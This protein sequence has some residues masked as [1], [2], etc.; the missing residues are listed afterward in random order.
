[1]CVVDM[2]SPC[3]RM[4]YWPLKAIDFKSPSGHSPFRALCLTGDS[5]N[6]RKTCAVRILLRFG[7]RLVVGDDPPNGHFQPIVQHGD[8]LAYSGFIGLSKYSNKTPR[9][10][11]RGSLYTRVFS[12]YYRAFL[13]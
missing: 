9:V 4:G 13:L 1:M 2:P 5:F 6:I 12:V 11:P 3:D 10:R 7:T 8:S